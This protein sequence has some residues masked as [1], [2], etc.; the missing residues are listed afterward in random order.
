MESR[1]PQAASVATTALIRT[2]GGIGSVAALWSDRLTRTLRPT[3]AGRQ[4]AFASLHRHTFLCG[5]T[6]GA[7]AVPRAAETF[8]GS[9][10]AICC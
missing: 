8:S 9:C 1:H 10:Q 7:L 3:S 4:H 2:P 5:L 6:L